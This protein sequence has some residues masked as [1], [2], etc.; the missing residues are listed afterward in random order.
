MTL[1][2][3]IVQIRA[4]AR[5]MDAHYGRTVF[6]E[7]AVISLQENQARVLT[8]LGPRNDDFMANFAKDLGTLRAGLLNASYGVGDFEFARHG[9][10]TGFESFMVL[11]RALYLICNNTRDSMDS[12]AKNPRWLAAQVPFAEL[13]EKVRANP[14]AVA[15]DDTK[16]SRKN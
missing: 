4:C 15:G 3:T 14:L 12:I 9:I 11:G 7:W 2:E 13:S 6:D 8:Y 10:G 1:E 16:I 5:Q